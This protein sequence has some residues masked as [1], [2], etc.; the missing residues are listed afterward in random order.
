MEILGRLIFSIQEIAVFERGC[1]T[2]IET[3][4][5]SAIYKRL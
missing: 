3:N 5:Q 2:D 1:A 4:G